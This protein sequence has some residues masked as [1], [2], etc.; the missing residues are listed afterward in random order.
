MGRREA[1]LRAYAHVR[2][3]VTADQLADE[4]HGVFALTAQAVGDFSLGQQDGRIEGCD[5]CHGAMLLAAG[6]IRLRAPKN[7][8]PRAAPRRQRPAPVRSLDARIASEASVMIRPTGRDSLR[9]V[10]ST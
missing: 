2:N 4:A 10:Q 5:V 8:W 3:A 9:L 7:V 1:H 6:L